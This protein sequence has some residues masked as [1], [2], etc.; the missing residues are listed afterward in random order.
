MSGKKPARSP[1]L[2]ES[3]AR[4]VI[5]GTS[6]WVSL[7]STPCL[8]PQRG[9][10]SWGS[11]RQPDNRLLATVVAP[12]LRAPFLE[13]WSYLILR[14]PNLQNYMMTDFS[15]YYLENLTDWCSN[16]FI[17]NLPLLIPK[18]CKKGIKKITRIL[19]IT[20]KNSI[21]VELK[22]FPLD[23]CDQGKRNFIVIPL[24]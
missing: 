7:G 6:Y 2:M 1:H 22:D 21:H 19:N 14:G 23:S 5:Q 18:M 20:S 24:G 10:L 11:Y 8:A 16:A 9:A 3:Q 15:V 4:T 13:A 17:F 12:L